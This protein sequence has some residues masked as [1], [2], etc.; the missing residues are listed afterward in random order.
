MSAVP[1]ILEENFGSRK[2][3][4]FVDGFVSSILAHTTVST[5]CHTWVKRDRPNRRLVI[6][7]SMATG[8]Q[9]TLDEDTVNN[10]K[11]HTVY[12]WCL[13]EFLRAVTFP[14]IFEQVKCFLDAHIQLSHAPADR[15]EM[16]LV[17]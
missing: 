13:A 11:T 3:I 9:N 8:G 17:G 4:V 1:K 5:L 16:D 2:H 7:C 6:L 10:I 12:S 15:N 14:E